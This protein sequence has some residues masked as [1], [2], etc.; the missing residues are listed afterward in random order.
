MRRAIC[1]TR[2]WLLLGA[3]GIGLVAALS[4]TETSAEAIHVA[5]PEILGGAPGQNVVAGTVFFIQPDSGPVVVIGAA[6]SFDMGKLARAPGVEFRLGHSGRSVARSSRF[7][8]APGKPFSDVAGSFADDFVVFSL[9]APADGVTPLEAIGP[10]GVRAGDRVRLLGVPANV[11]RDQ[12]SILGTVTRVAT[13]RIELSLDAPESLRGWGGAPVVADS[14]GRV[15]GLVEAQWPVRGELRIGAAPIGPIL[16]A[17]RTP[18]AGGRGEPFASFAPTG[19][20]A[21]GTPP[22]S[23]W[24]PPPPPSPTPRAR[25]AARPVPAPTPGAATPSPAPPGQDPPETVLQSSGAFDASGRENLHLLGPSTKSSPKLQLEIEY[26]EEEAIFGG[27]AGGFLT[28]RAIASEAELQRFDIVL[29][30]DTSGSTVASSGSDING[31]G[32]IGTDR[33]AGLFGQ[34]DPGD[35]ILAA[36]IAAARRLLESLDPRVARVA[37]VTFAGAPPQGGRGIT[38]G[39]GGGRG[40]PAVTEEP[41]T[42]QHERIHHALD[43]VLSRGP[44]GQ[45]HMAAGVDQAM[46]ELKGLPGGLSKVD[47]RSEKVVFFLTDGIPTLPYDGNAIR[48][49]VEATLRAANRSARVGVTVHTFAIGPEAL[50]GPIAPVEIAARTG[51]EFT[52]VRHPAD[53]V[54]AIELVNLANIEEI[55]VRNLTNDRD[56][57]ELIVSADGSWS[58]LVPLEPGKNNIEVTVTASDGQ[59]LRRELQLQHAPGAD[60]PALPPQHVARRNRLLQERLLDLKRQGK[61]VELRAADE[62]RRELALQIERDRDAAQARADAQRKELQLEIGR[63]PAAPPAP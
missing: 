6:H 12:S 46:I 11:P 31:N 40:A 43:R 3:L 62:M 21:R 4:G 27:S 5:R 10:E 58:A 26:P 25:A 19:V 37:L 44:W 18:L 50:A 61:E 38:I 23:A 35:S 42:S 60:M 20:A 56:A 29:V 7:P 28:G 52:P 1:E 30:L 17:L 13:G 24:P 63:D 8:I 33:F 45:T 36:E 51:G 9:D 57:D 14:S 39:G 32:V 59:V 48:A 16:A 47:A 15:I 34:T 53:I 2:L 22:P 49:N 41:L 55:T 54:P